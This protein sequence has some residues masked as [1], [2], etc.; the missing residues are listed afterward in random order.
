MLE[1]LYVRCCGIDIHKFV[2]VACV[3]VKGKLG[4]KVILEE[5]PAA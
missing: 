1:I 2:A 5:L 3:V 4:F